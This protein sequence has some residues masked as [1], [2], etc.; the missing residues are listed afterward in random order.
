MRDRQEASDDVASK[1]KEA[2]LE[3]PQGGKAAI[4]GSQSDPLIAD[5][6]AARGD[7]TRPMPNMDAKFQILTQLGWSA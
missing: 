4:L 3:L 2:G 5:R 7:W 6:V 1:R